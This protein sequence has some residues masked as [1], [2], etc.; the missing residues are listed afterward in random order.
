MPNL[1]RI[2]Y[3]LFGAIRRLDL[4]RDK[5]EKYKNKQLRKVV[6]YAFENVRFY[7]DLFKASRVNAE[8]IRNTHDLN[9]LPI[10]RKKEMRQ[11][12][13][14]DLISK[15]FKDQ[16]L[17]SLTTGGSTGEPFSVYI[18]GKE[19]DWRKAIYL[20]AN[21]TCGQ[22]LR[23]R[24][25]A[26]D[27]AERAIETSFLNRLFGVFIREVV[28]VTWDRHSQLQA[29]AR[30]SPDILD[31]FSGVIWL[32]AKEAEARNIEAIHPRIIFGT[33]DLIDKA[34]RNY[35]EKVFNAPY[36][37]QFGCAEV[38]RTAWQCPERLGYHIDE[39]SVIMQFV[40]KN[41]EE[42][43]PG[44]R[45]EIVCTSLF[46]YAM[47]FIRYGT[48]DIGVPMDEECPCG[49]KLPL[50]KVVEGRSNSFLVFPDGH[51]V[52]PMSFIEILKAFTLAEEI[53]RYRV[54][55]KTKNLIEVYVKK[56]KEDV[57]EER[58]RSWLLA[59]ILEGLPKVEK[60]DL[61]KVTFEVKFVDEFPLSGRGKL[62]V[63][64]SHVPAFS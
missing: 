24:W 57:D 5:L 36:Y 21:I 40:D 35:L 49:R 10:I 64:V 53:D 8:D 16:K 58:I 14:D 7:H 33:G 54:I 25:V 51:V 63:V 34:S 45:G 28:P 23:D 22:R 61:S 31:G 30:L 37:D 46:N 2:S 41:G 9:K 18:C 47:P 32:L 55:Q 19:D 4:S 60:V 50:M 6:K 44:E 42:V 12:D 17:K 29:I 52:A 39:D 13:R 26:I 3:Y 20:R 48:M 59:N 43:A 56:T 38:D 11:H 15:D 62:N 1:A 27:V